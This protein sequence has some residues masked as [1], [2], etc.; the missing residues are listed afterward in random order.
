MGGIW[1]V[2]AKFPYEIWE[3]WE[4]FFTTVET[5]SYKSANFSIFFTMALK[6]DCPTGFLY[7]SIIGIRWKS[8]KK[9]LKGDL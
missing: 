5:L 3:I 2:L 9:V 8:V 4:D 6:K 1:E 7:F